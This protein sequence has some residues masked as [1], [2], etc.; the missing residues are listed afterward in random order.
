MP[1]GAPSRPAPRGSQA[2]ATPPRKRRNFT[3]IAEPVVSGQ[4]GVRRRAARGPSLAWGLFL[5]GPKLVQDTRELHEVHLPVSVPKPSWTWPR[6]SVD[7]VAA[8]VHEGGSAGRS[9]RGPPGLDVVSI[10]PL[11]AWGARSRHPGSPAWPCGARAPPPPPRGQ[12]RENKG[13]RPA[14]KM[15]QA[16]GRAPGRCAALC[17]GPSPG[18][19]GA[20][21]K[22]VRMG[23]GV[24]ANSGGRPGAASSGG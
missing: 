5:F 18:T 1:F 22:A 17:L 4:D 2:G 7:T 19:R 12:C 20:S 21:A 3:P 16:S 13:T 8:A 24:L 9:R 23:T 14:P 15:V 6:P 10:R 11:K